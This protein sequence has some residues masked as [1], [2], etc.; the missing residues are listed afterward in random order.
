MNS[1]IAANVKP[2]FSFNYTVS[3]LSNEKQ[4]KLKKND[5]LTD[6]YR[7]DKNTFPVV[8][9]WYNPVTHNCSFSLEQ[10]RNLDRLDE[11]K[12]FADNWDGYGSKKIDS[13]IIE[14]SKQLIIYM[15]H[16]PTIF[17]TAR[18]SIQM[19]FELEDRSYLEFEVFS[20]HIESLMVPKRVYK[21]AISKI[22]D[23]GDIHTVN[24]IIKDFYE[25]IT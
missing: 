23:D 16:Q 24:S 22:I 21:D 14:K 1:T 2:T 8:V 20:N 25:R 10:L 6:Y 18:D 17:P 15:Q 13:I 3:Q 12:C 9:A 19:Q 11:I 4:Y 7:S 5:G